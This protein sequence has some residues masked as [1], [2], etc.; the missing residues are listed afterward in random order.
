MV[1]IFASGV[2][3]SDYDLWGAWS[4]TD[5][6]TRNRLADDIAEDDWCLAIGMQSK[7]T[8]EH[9]RGR[10]LALLKIGPELIETRQMVE[11]AHWRRSVE[12]F[13]DRKWRYA[14]PIRHVERFDSGPDGLPRRKDILSRIDR[15]NL[16]MQVGRYYLELRSEEVQ[17]VLA[18]PRT[19]E[20]NIYQSPVSAFASRLLKRPRGPRP[21]PGT[22][23]LTTQSGPAATY[24]AVLTG[25]AA[26][27]FSQ[28]FN[29]PDLAFWKLGFSRSPERRLQE[30][31]AFLPC[32]Q[33]LCWAPVLTQW[34]EDEINAYAMEQRMFDL[35][36]Q[37]GHRLIKGEMFALDEGAVQLLWH[38]AKRSAARPNGP[39]VVSTGW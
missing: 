5:E 37:Q 11:A 20:P 27:L 29:H 8:P 30:L 18:L 16:Y 17:R 22:R 2:F 13:G 33:T 36:E 34:H 38:D 9:E 14:F 26:H 12:Q 39:V 3:G 28:R 35:L 15:D 4:F 7:H 10:L 24:L 19:H 21:S 25:T 1:R 32:E 23:L 31:N 6:R